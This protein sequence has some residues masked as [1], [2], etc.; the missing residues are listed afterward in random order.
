MHTVTRLSDPE[1][2]R[3]SIKERMMRNREVSIKESKKRRK[4]RGGWGEVKD[5]VENRK[6]RDQGTI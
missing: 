2:A 4:K 5:L 6:I 1:S 3:E